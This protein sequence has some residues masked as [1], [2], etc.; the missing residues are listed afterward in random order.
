[1]TWHVR[2]WPWLEAAVVIALAIAAFATG[3]FAFGNAPVTPHFYQ[4]AFGP[5]IMV[6]AGHGFVNPVA[7]PGSPLEQFM[8][9][10]IETL[11]VADATPAAIVPPD[12]FQHAHRFVFT[13]VGLWWRLSGIDWRGLD[14]VVGV[15]HALGVMAV[16][17]LVRQFGP[18]GAALAAAAW[19][20]ISPLQL[21]YAQQFR[22]FVKG[23]F[24]L[25]VL[26]LLVAAIF[27]AASRRALLWT[28]GAA[29]AVMGIGFGFKMDLAIMVP[30]AA[31]VVLLF[32][33][34]WPWSGL[35]EK[36]LAVAV[37]VAA[38]YVTAGPILTQLSR[39]GSN[40]AH[41][42]LLGAGERFD[43]PLHVDRAHYR[44]FPYY[45]DDYAI[46]A[47]RWR[48]ETE[49]RQH[50]GVPSPEYERAGTALWRDMLAMFPADAI[51]RLLASAERILNFAF[52]NAD[53]M[54]V[55]AEF[56]AHRWIRPAF[57]WLDA[58]HGW[59]SALGA[60]FV[61]AASVRSVRHGLF[62]AALTIM[63]AGYPSLQFDARH[64]VHLQALPI[65]MIALLVAGAVRTVAR[66]RDAIEATALR[67]SAQR[68]VVVA[69]V[70]VILMVPVT[71]LRAY[72]HRQVERTFAEF[73]A[74]P[75]EVIEPEWAR[76]P[77]GR[78]IA[79]WPGMQGSP[80]GW[81]DIHAAYYRVRFRAAADGEPV[82]FAIRHVPP[83]GDC[84]RIMAAS[85]RRGESHLAFPV[86]SY[87]L[88]SAFDGIEMGEWTKQRLVGIYRHATGPANL[89]VELRLPQEWRSG[90]LFQTLASEGRRRAFDIDVAATV[91]S[92]DAPLQYA[93][94]IGDPA[95]AVDEHA[96]AER[97][98]TSLRT[99]DGRVAMD[100]PATPAYV[101]QF[102]PV[103]LA[104]GEALVAA[105]DVDA[106][107]LTLGLMRDGEWQRYVTVARAGERVV[108]V[109]VDEPGVYLPMVANARPGRS[110]SRFTIHRLGIVSADGRG[111]PLPPAG[112][113]RP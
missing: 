55:R 27:G 89:P 11:P 3:R 90:P 45:S 12:Q 109:P 72:Q 102:A 67:R 37:M 85:I 66:W 88:G 59:G 100:G 62:A 81:G 87:R 7:A 73:L 83:F 24:I 46:Y 113:G 96:I 103:T 92:C 22:D 58:W 20:C 74:A 38:F 4:A 40:V 95:L 49:A 53:P 101:A 105:I 76:T 36:L 23:P 41:V 52:V 35:P 29:G 44:S 104:A 32:R 91:S 39:G 57:A 94:A 1:M 108:G 51:T 82:A 42:A 80:N 93:D 86:Y 6:A 34:A 48:S 5:A 2:R 43:A 63:L 65:A 18:A 9:R 69:A 64:Y 71:A 15:L 56:P 19:F 50:I 14:A 99:R 25:A 17:A 33:G 8:G 60:V 107:G 70:V 98:T 28:M 110:T 111:R 16:Y 78:W 106:G 21:G 10:A 79:R 30:I 77:E 31:L 68:A 75:A 97:F 61:A 47:I 13:A 26:P 112:E 84:P 54:A